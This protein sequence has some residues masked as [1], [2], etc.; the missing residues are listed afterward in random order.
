[1]AT[2]DRSLLE[3]IPQLQSQGFSI[4]FVVVDEQSSTA[5]TKQGELSEIEQKRAAVADVEAVLALIE[6]KGGQRAYG[7]LP[8]P[9]GGIFAGFLDPE[10]HLVGAGVGAEIEP[11]LISHPL[12]RTRPVVLPA[13][14]RN[15]FME[16]RSAPI[17]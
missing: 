16:C 4:G 12:R 5:P 1:V 10:G 17:V 11:N 6:S 13:Q 8:T 15:P 9:D 14:F 3:A 7:P 2:Y